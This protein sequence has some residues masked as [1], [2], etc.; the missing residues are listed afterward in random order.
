MKLDVYEM[1]EVD[2]DDINYTYGIYAPLSIRLIQH[3]SKSDSKVLSDILPLL[4][5][6]IVEHVNPDVDQG[7][8]AH[9]IFEK[10]NYLNTIIIYIA[11]NMNFLVDSQKVVLVFFVGGCTFAEISALRFLSSLEDCKSISL[12]YSTKNIVDYNC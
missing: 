2:P 6:P 1:S 11:P 8:K 3:I 10:I 7:N 12:I 4:P 5:G 9:K